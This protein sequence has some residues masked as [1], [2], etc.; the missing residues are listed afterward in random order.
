MVA[1]VVE[2]CHGCFVCLCVCVCFDFLCFD[3][4]CFCFWIFCFLIFVLVWVCLGV[5]L[6]FS[7][8]K[9]ECKRL[10]KV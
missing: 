4:L 7:R 8:K 9:L 2:Y 5:Y 10:C 3:F 1:A 6:E